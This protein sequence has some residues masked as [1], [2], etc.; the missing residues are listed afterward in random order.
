[1]AE[2]EDDMLDVGFWVEDITLE[3]V[4]LEIS[5]ALFM[6]WLSAEDV[7]RDLSFLVQ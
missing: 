7:C 1:M 5:V 4:R 6:I 3:W 2:L